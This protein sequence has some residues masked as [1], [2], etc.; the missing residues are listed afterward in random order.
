MLKNPCSRCGKERIISRTWIEIIKTYSGKSTL[1]HTMSICPDPVCQRKVDGDIAAA[2]EHVATLLRLKLEREKTAM[3]N[4]Q[5]A[6]ELK[7]KN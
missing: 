1:T 7:S 2:K 5:K 4:R 6:K 3:E